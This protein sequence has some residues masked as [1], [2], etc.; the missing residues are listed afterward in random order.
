MLQPVM[1]CIV[2]VGL[3]LLLDPIKQIL[4]FSPF[5]HCFSA[6]HG[7]IINFPDFYTASNILYLACINIYDQLKDHILCPKLK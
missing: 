1:G 3:N 5:C 7:G 2:G 6:S 4:L